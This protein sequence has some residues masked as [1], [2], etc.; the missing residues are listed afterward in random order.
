MVNQIKPKLNDNSINPTMELTLFSQQVR[1]FLI[2]QQIG[3]DSE[4]NKYNPWINSL[5][6]NPFAQ[7]TMSDNSYDSGYTYS[8]ATKSNLISSVLYGGFD[9]WSGITAPTW[10]TGEGDNNLALISLVNA[11]Q[12][13]YNAQDANYTNLSAA[14]RG[15][16]GP[17]KEL[18]QIHLANAFARDREQRNNIKIFGFQLAYLDRSG[19]EGNMLA[20]GNSYNYGGFLTQTTGWNQW[21]ALRCITAPIL[22]TIDTHQMDSVAFAISYSVKDLVVESQANY[23]KGIDSSMQGQVGKYNNE[24]LPSVQNWEAQVANYDRFY[25]EWKVQAD[26]ARERAQAEYEASIASLEAEKQAWIANSQKEYRDGYLQWSELSANAQS[27]K[28]MPADIKTEILNISSNNSYAS[29]KPVGLTTLVDSFNSSLESIAGQGFTFTDQPADSFL[30]A[31]TRLQAGE[32]SSG[33][34]TLLGAYNQKAIN[35]SLEIGGKEY[36][37]IIQGT[38]TGIYQYSQLISVNDSNQQLA[39]REQEKMLNQNSWNIEYSA[40]EIGTMVDGQYVGTGLKDEATINSIL[41]EFNNGAR[42][43]I[44]MENCQKEAKANVDCFSDV[45]H[46]GRMDQLSSLGYEYKD[47][48]VVRK[49]DRSEEIRLGIFKDYESMTQA[50]KEEYGSCYVD[51]SLCKTTNGKNLLR[52]DFDYTIDKQTNIATLTRVINNGKISSRNGD[53]FTNGTQVESRSLNLAQVKSVMAPKGKDLFDTWGQ[54]DW[55]N[56]SEQSTEKLKSFYEVGLVAV[57]K[58]TQNAVASIRKV[59]SFNEKK[60][61]NTVEGIKNQESMLKELALAY[62]TGGMAGVQAAIKGKVEDKINSSLAEAFIRATGGT[63]E[64]V[65]RVSDAF[66]FVRGRIEQNK[67]KAR[68]NYYSVNDLGGSFERYLKNIDPVTSTLRRTVEVLPQ[69]PIIG[70]LFTTM[71]AVTLTLAKEALG[72]KNYNSTMD[73]ITASKDRIV[74]IKANERS[75]AKSYV[76]K[77]ISEGSGLSLELVSQQS[78]DFLGAR[79]AA[80]VRNANNARWGALDQVVGVVGGIVKTAFNAFGM[81]DRDFAAALKDA[82]RLAF[83]GNLDTTY[84]EKAALA[85][86]NQLWGMS[87]PGLSYQTNVLKIGDNKGIA[88]E[89]G[90]QA[91]VT[92]IA[93]A[94]GWDKDIVNSIVRKEYGKY[95]QKKTDKKV[96]ADAI[97]D[98]AKLAATI[99]LPGGIAAI[100]GQFASAAGQIGQIATRIADFAD[101]SSKVFNAIVRGVVQVVDGTRN[102]INGVAAGLGNAVLGVMGANGMFDFGTN[103]GIFSQSAVGLGISYDKDRGYG[104]MIGIG[105]STTNASVGFYQHGA[106]S[107]D[108]SYGVS[109]YSQVTLSHSGNSTQVGM[110]VNGGEGDRKGFN[111]S[112]NYDIQQGMASGS[113]GYTMPDE[114]SPFN[115]MGI[116]LNFDR[117]GMTS[118]AQYNGINLASM[119]PSGFSMQEI[120]WAMLNINDAQDRQKFNQDKT[121]LED[122]NKKLSV[123]DKPYID[124]TKVSDKDIENLANN[125]RS[126]ERLIASKTETPESLKGLNPTE[127]A[128]KLDALQQKQNTENTAAGAAATGSL[129][130]LMLGYLGL[131]RKENEGGVVVNENTLKVEPIVTKPKTEKVRKVADEKPKVRKEGVQ[132]GETD[133]AKKRNSKSD[134]KNTEVTKQSLK[135]KLIKTGRDGLEFGLKV[136]DSLLFGNLSADPI[137]NDRKMPLDRYERKDDPSLEKSKTGKEL[138]ESQAKALTKIA[139]ITDTPDYLNLIDSK[140]KTLGKQIRLQEE[141]NTLKKDGYGAQST[142]ILTKQ[143]ELKDVNSTL[144]K[145]NKDLKPK[146]LIKA[147]AELA[148]VNRGIDKY[149]ADYK[150]SE[151]TATRNLNDSRKI[152]FGSTQKGF[153]TKYKAV[154]DKN[155]LIQ[156]SSADKGKVD[157]M[158]NR[159]KEISVKQGL[160]KNIEGLLRL[161]ESD[162]RSLLKESILTPSERAF[163]NELII[164]GKEVEVLGKNSTQA[165]SNFLREAELD[166]NFSKL[167]KELGDSQSFKKMMTEFSREQKNL[168]I[169]SNRIIDT[170]LTQDNMQYSVGDRKVDNQE[171]EKLRQANFKTEA[172]F[173]KYQDTYLRT[174][175]D[176]ITERTEI[177]KKL[178]TKDLSSN[179]RTR[180]EARAKALDENIFS[181]KIGHKVG[182]DPKIYMERIIKSAGEE[183]QALNQLRSQYEGQLEIAK[184]NNDSKAKETLAISIKAINDRLLNTTLLSERAARY[185]EWSKYVVHGQDKPIQIDTSGDFK[186]SPIGDKNNGDIRFTSH[187]GET[188][189]GESTDPLSNFVYGSFHRGVD[190][191]GNMRDP[192]NSMFNGRDIS[193]TYGASIEVAATAK[194]RDAGVIYRPEK[195]G[196][197][198]GL[199]IGNRKLTLEEIQGIDSGI[200][201]TSPL[202]KHMGLFYSGTADGPFDP[203]K[204]GTIEKPKGTTSGISPEQ[205]A[206]INFPKNP[207]FTDISELKN[208]H[209]NGN[210]VTMT[211]T[212]KGKYAGDYRISYKH[213]DDV[214]LVD[215]STGTVN[216]GDRI[217]N[218]GSTGYSTGPHLHVQV[219]Y[220]STT[221]PPN[222]SSDYYTIDRVEKRIINGLETKINVYIINPHYFEDVMVTKDTVAP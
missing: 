177:A 111:L 183:V 182:E 141:I 201:S 55:E 206:A 72:D 64:D 171:I 163:V 110:N 142:E 16:L 35:T 128:A 213:L 81:K 195:N 26:V 219:E 100:A 24:I 155:S 17:D 153:E 186:K 170:T 203:S 76:D 28:A 129:A 46:K 175:K 158:Q 41:K 5:Q 59:E 90:Q 184:K 118:T 80:R 21:G 12:A 149:V 156:L 62:L 161:S 103:M 145:L 51:P 87:G 6:T 71:N 19:T 89:L 94:Q 88:K 185:D 27:G 208:I 96:Q 218:L 154:T 109:D 42:Y 159:F 60:F 38:T 162:I 75:M 37:S 10:W 40:I 54:E 214:P 83:A 131:G 166:A 198:A 127:I 53:E 4:F 190:I 144:E 74:E 157:S 147:E 86:A 73:R 137:R 69:I 132:S 176:I 22:C 108:A 34:Y 2:D 115:G 113:I 116:N 204:L 3:A 140:V 68:D 124:L 104:G 123:G 138:K 44:A 173:I 165:N 188:G 23:W 63:M 1:D 50:E 164:R 56:F 160:Y 78:T 202:T 130:F 148:K 215:R 220:A 216:A 197:E 174:R 13:D 211:T 187:F 61:Q 136:A 114:S 121:Y 193:I 152:G 67:I 126:K 189:Y 122:L 30:N 119:G 25:T 192:V 172:D 106:T 180:L 169:E 112:L 194:L 43:Q 9:Y 99:L 134:G 82:N 207:S 117:Y 222:I 212:L 107:L 102:G 32:S 105:N 85:G 196:Y 209:S 15:Y 205:Y 135:D 29:I 120:D 133:P 200:K 58:T 139:E 52:K 199:Y 217:G 84:G 65:Q 14:L 95:E 98:T 7:Y 91:L 97:R 93:K 167:V 45:V 79:D 33:S 181:H 221:P 49:L 191:A 125:E 168:M 8:D 39:L 18:T 11:L 150:S 143:R 57:G 20:G 151:E 101:K 178:E 92:A 36:S 31:T 210:S 70:P 146:K 66:S 179:E 47:G 77:A 48:K